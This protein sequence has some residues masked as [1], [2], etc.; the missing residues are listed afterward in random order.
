MD[1]VSVVSSNLAAVAYE[2]SSNTL[3][4]RFNHG[5]TYSYSN[6]PPSVHQGL[7][8]APSH[9]KYFAQYIKNSYPYRKL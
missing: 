2:E 9:G 6:V 1:F 3:Y 5:G 7:M 8:S 4:I